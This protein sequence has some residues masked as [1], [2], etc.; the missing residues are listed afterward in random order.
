M[1]RQDP[2]VT[3]P[4]MRQGTEVFEKAVDGLSDD[5]LRAPSAL[6]D[7]TRAHVIGHLA[8]NAEALTRL[9]MWA[10]TGVETPMYRD[11]DARNSDIDKSVTFSPMQLRT[12]LIASAAALEAG[13][14]RL[15]ER[16][17]QAEVR[18]ALGRTLPAS[19]VPWMRVREVWLHALDLDAGV[20]TADFPPA[21]VDELLDDVSAVVGAKPDCP[22]IQLC[23]TDRKKSWA[24]GSDHLRPEVTGSAA[25]LLAWVAGR[26]GGS[27][28]AGSS[29]VRLPPWI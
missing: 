26:S 25:D 21:L 8:R 29:T 20:S 13:F 3:L 12:D 22:S 24:L 17:W 10:E 7:W 2:A 9:T 1:G 19:G 16:T 18:S 5:E 23:A 28:L 27:G 14:A 6:P 4:W 15:D 11:L